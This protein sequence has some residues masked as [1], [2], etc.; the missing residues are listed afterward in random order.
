MRKAT[1]FGFY[2][3]YLAGLAS[4]MPYVVLYYQELGFTGAQ[5]GLLAGMAPLI[6][7]VGAP[8]WTGIADATRRHRLVMSLAIGGAAILAL[9]FPILKTL[10]PMLV[11]VALY[12]LFTAPIMSLAD[13]GTMSMLAGQKE[14]YGRIRLGGTFGWALAAPIAGML[15]QT[16]GLKLAFR[17]YAGLMFLVLVICQRFVFAHSPDRTPIGNG[18]RTLMTNRHWVLFLVLAFAGGMGFASVN[19]FFFAYMQELNANETTMGLALTVSAIA[20]LPVL[21]FANRLLKHFGAR[22]LFFLGMMITGVRLLLYAALSSPAGVLASQILNG[23]TYPI[24]WVAGVSYAN[25]SAPA[26]MSATMQGLFGAMVYGFGAAAGG[27][28]GG[29]LLESIGGRGLYLVFGLI[30][31]VSLSIITLVDRRLPVDT[32]AALM[33]GESASK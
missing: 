28:L 12:A 27:F 23:L 17:S 15:V 8:L 30:L 5:I 25:Q 20:E 3:F 6:T 1:A 29:P 7:L 32:K 19:N 16:Y 26:G 13:S 21:F 4:L 2:F 22:N 9:I 18:I 10:G 33:P 31:L 14:M 11:L 24:A